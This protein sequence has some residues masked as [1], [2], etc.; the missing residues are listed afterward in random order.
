M[1]IVFSEGSTVTLTMT[2]D[3]FQ[4]LRYALFEG[5]MKLESTA[6]FMKA[7]KSKE[8]KSSNATAKAAR[9]VCDALEATTQSYLSK[10]ETKG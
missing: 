3:Q 10:P 2:C 1:K 9:G 8:A 5:A 7:M 6:R 4:S